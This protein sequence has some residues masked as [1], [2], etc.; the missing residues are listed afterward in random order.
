MLQVVSD[1]V[2]VLTN[3][4]IK[5]AAVACSNFNKETDSVV[6]KILLID[7]ANSTLR[8]DI[9]RLLHLNVRLVEVFGKYL[10]I[11]ALEVFLI[12][13]KQS[14]ADHFYCVIYFVV[15]QALKVFS[16]HFEEIFQLRDGNDFDP[17][18]SE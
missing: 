12:T 7:E 3:Q 4:S 10:Q 1:Q 9:Q 5:Y 18:F 11:N 8:L 16:K 14:Q 6:L 2:L 13:Q 15:L 17:V